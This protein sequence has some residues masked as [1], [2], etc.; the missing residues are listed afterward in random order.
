MKHGRVNKT[1]F[2]PEE[3]GYNLKPQSTKHTSQILWNLYQNESK[4]LTSSPLSSDLEHNI[5]HFFFP[6]SN[7]PDL[8]SCG[9]WFS[10]ENYMVSGSGP[11]SRAGNM[12]LWKLQGRRVW[13]NTKIPIPFP[14]TIFGR[15]AVSREAREGKLVKSTEFLCPRLSMQR[16]VWEPHCQL[17]QGVCWKCRI[18]GQAST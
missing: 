15:D 16:V 2:S 18:R 7:N 9:H 13:R 11:G 3:G 5:T 14:L 4:N 17:H 6:R 1:P 12:P 10:D 8:R